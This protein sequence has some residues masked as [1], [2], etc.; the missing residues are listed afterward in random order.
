MELKLATA[1]MVLNYASYLEEHDFF[2]DSFRVYEKGV[3]LFRFPH[4]KDIWLAYLQ[5]FSERYGGS[6]PSS[7]RATC[8]SSRS[9]RCPRRMRRNSSSCTRGSR[10]STAF[11]RHA[12]AIFDRAT[13]AV[14]EKHKLDMYLLYIRRREKH[15]G[16]ARTR[17]I[18]ER[19]IKVLP[20]E[21]AKQMC[22]HFMSLERKLGEIDHRAAPSWLMVRKPRLSAALFG[23]HGAVL[24]GSRPA[25]PRRDPGYWQHL[26]RVRGGSMAT[27]TPSAK[28]CA[29]SGRY[30]RRSRRPTAASDRPAPRPGIVLRAERHL[31]LSSGQLH[32]VR[33]ARGRSARDVGP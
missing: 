23:S 11:M 15:Y 12:M 8:L 16:V 32:G 21:P 5:K 13:R 25:D 24:A 9:R 26:A 3:S 19:A 17:E 33:D 2:E 28:C 4:V 27:R 18:H 6:K 14:D 31:Y 10:K 7:A 22:L 1:Q 29:S 20:D 30:R